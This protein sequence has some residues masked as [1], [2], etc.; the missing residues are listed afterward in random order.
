MLFVDKD[1]ESFWDASL[2]N[3]KICKK[4]YQLTKKLWD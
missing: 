1:N 3:L 4:S 2:F